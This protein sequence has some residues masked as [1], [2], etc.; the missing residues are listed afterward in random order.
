M[1]HKIRSMQN[2]QRCTGYSVNWYVTKYI[3]KI[4]PNTLVVFS[5]NANNPKDIRTETTFLYNT[6]ILS[7]DFVERKRQ[8][9]SRSQ[10][11]PNGCTITRHEILQQL[12]MVS[13]VHTDLVFI[14]L[15]T[16]LL[17]SMQVFKSLQLPMKAHLMI[18]S[19]LLRTTN[20]AEMTTLPFLYAQTRFVE[21]RSFLNGVFILPHKS[22]L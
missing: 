13:Q 12:L 15:S 21:T 18:S 4:N 20:S 16:F 3:V 17:R 1:Y 19:S 6:K 14:D 5:I 22:L 9:Q 2:A 11:H 10:N 7:S 8:M